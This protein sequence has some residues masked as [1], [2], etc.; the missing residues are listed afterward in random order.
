MKSSENLDI[1]QA[2]FCMTWIQWKPLPMPGVALET[3][4]ET[5]VLER[6]KPIAYHH[7][8]LS[9]HMQTHKMGCLGRKKNT[10]KLYLYNYI[11]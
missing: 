9:A 5:H 4:Y 2:V 7:C 11:F 3:W 8:C 10:Y 6:C 1:S